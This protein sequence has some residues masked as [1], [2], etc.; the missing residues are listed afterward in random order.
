MVRCIALSE[1]QC[2]GDMIANVIVTLKQWNIGIKIYV[3]KH[4]QGRLPLQTTNL[5]FTRV[6][7][8]PFCSSSESSSAHQQHKQCQD[9]LDPSMLY[10]YVIFGQFMVPLLILQVINYGLFLLTVIHG[11]SPSLCSQ[12]NNPN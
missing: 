6:T 4:G 2:G 11:R 9:F 1:Q 12:S 10:L 8:L 3:T 5:K 7:Y